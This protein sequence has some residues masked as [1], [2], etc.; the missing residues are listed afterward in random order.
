VLARVH[1]TR[2][3][4]WISIIVT[5]IIGIIVIISSSGSI[6]KIATLEYS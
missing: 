6:S 3:T 5:M 4:P 2:R 1:A